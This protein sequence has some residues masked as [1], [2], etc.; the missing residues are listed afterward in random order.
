MLWR[1]EQRKTRSG[2]VFSPFWPE[3]TAALRSTT[4]DFAPLLRDSIQREG[5]PEDYERLPGLDEPPLLDQAGVDDL[6]LLDGSSIDECWPPAVPPPPAPPSPPPP[7]RVRLD[8][9]P[10]RNHHRHLKR[11][12]VRDSDFDASGHLIKQ[13]TLLAQV[14]TSKSRAL[15]AALDATTLPAAAGGYTAKTGDKRGSKKRRSLTEVLALGFKLVEWNGF[16]SQPIVDAR[17]RIVAV[18]AGQPRDETYAAAA[19]AAYSSLTKER[20]SAHFPASLS[21][22]PRGPFPALNVGLTYGKGQRVPSRLA[23]GIHSALLQ[24]L[25]GDPNIKRMAAYASAAFSLWAPKVYRYYKEHADTLH[26]RLPHL[27]R[28]FKRSVFSCAAFNFGP[29][30]WTFKHRDVMNVPF[31]WCAVQ[32]LGRFNARKGGHLVLWDFKLVIEFP[33]GATIL[34]PSATVAHSNIP[35]QAG[36]ERASFTQYTAGGLIR[37]VDNGFCTEAELLER[38]PV[39]YEKMWADKEARWEMGIGLFSTI[40]ELLEPL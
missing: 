8:S 23:T 34:L 13:S 1:P 4:F 5:N 6:P 7:K 15:S 30:V 12:R 38:D 21:K 36:D 3:S 20:A 11:R 25:I 27:S 37:Y 35:V 19:A 40:D 26:H 39:A 14:A 16:D 29:D 10:G 31:G 17:G 2:A 9:V 33:A 32:A 18:L 28:N 24:R 22:Q